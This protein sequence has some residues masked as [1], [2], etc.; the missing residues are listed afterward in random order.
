MILS[1]VDIKQNHILFLLIFVIWLL[2]FNNS[3]LAI[4]EEWSEAG[5]YSHGYLV[6][7]LTAYIFWQRKDRFSSVLQTPNWLGVLAALGFGAL[8]W[9]ATVVNVLIVQEIAAVGLFDAILLAIYGWRNFLALQF[10]VFLLVLALPIWSFLSAPLR[11]LSTSVSYE[12]LKLLNIPVLLEGYLVTVPGG[13]FKVELGCSGLSFF[14]A[15]I[16]LGVLFGY[17]NQLKTSKTVCFAL[18]AACLA[19][20]S[21]WIRIITIILVGNYT[22]MQHVIVKDHLT[23]GWIVF[24]IALVPLFWIGDKFFVRPLVTAATNPADTTLVSHLDVVKD[25]SLT[26]EEPI[27]KLAASEKINNPSE[28]DSPTM[29]VKVVVLCI[30]LLLLF[31][32][33]NT[34]LTKWGVDESY[35]YEPPKFANRGLIDNL[36]AKEINWRPRYLG[37]SSEYLAKY[38]FNEQDLYLY[39]AN[40]AQ[41]KQGEELIFA[42]NSL[43]DEDLWRKTSENVVELADNSSGDYFRLQKFKSLYAGKRL[44]AYWYIVG[45]KTVVSSGQAK[46][47]EAVGA[48]TGQRG[49]SVIALAMDYQQ[50]DDEEAVKIATSFV[51]AIKQKLK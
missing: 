9:V 1:R 3:I 38:Q 10:P 21:N 30:C 13:Q 41:Q 18:F 46:F 26:A 40:Y 49:G 39:I 8:W 14:L 19:I 28:A 29:N 43:N 36:Y 37:A 31:P 35:G 12:M 42:K 4:T 24:A 20:F 48:I 25:S 33:M 15:A 45:G 51:Q 32:M 44:I 17:F 2:A 7:L 22:Q 23:F 50:L 11:D 34:M 5:A 27:A 47:R 6:F 16:S